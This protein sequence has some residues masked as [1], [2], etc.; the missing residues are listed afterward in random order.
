M[1]AHRVPLMDQGT[2][3]SPAYLQ[4]HGEPVDLDELRS[5]MA[6]SYVSSA[7]G[8]A[9]GLDFSLNNEV[10]EIDL[11]SIVAVTG[12]DLYTGAALSGLGLVQVPRSRIVTELARGRLKVVLPCLAQ[13]PMPVSVV[14]PQN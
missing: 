12:A 13:P 9:L 5:H 6:V 4:R 2:V 1:I 11:R 14:Y 3:A 7:T 8:R 10:I